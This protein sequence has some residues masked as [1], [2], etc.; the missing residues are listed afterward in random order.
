ME[1]DD[2]EWDESVLSSDVFECMLDELDRRAAGHGGHE[3]ADVAFEDDEDMENTGHV[4]DTA[5]RGRTDEEDLDFEDFVV[6][7]PP[8]LFSNM[9]R[10]NNQDAQKVVG[11]DISNGSDPRTPRTTGLKQHQP[12]ERNDPLT[13]PACG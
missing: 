5:S 7:S 4:E 11:P 8:P 6:I 13:L 12:R 10:T 3:D 1:L 9:A 2:K